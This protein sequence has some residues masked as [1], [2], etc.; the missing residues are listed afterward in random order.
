ME[1]EIENIILKDK[2]GIL[3]CK[4]TSKC[5]YHNHKCLATFHKF[6]NEGS[7]TVR[8]LVSQMNDKMQIELLFFLCNLL[9]LVIFPSNLNKLCLV[10]S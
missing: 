7:E 5:C 4:V 9:C 1:K 6:P 10:F 8:T 3:Y 2:H